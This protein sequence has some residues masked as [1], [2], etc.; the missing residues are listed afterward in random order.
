MFKNDDDVNKD[1]KTLTLHPQKD[2]MPLLEKGMHPV[3][4]AARGLDAHIEKVCNAMR[5]LADYIG[6][7]SLQHQIWWSEADDFM[8]SIA[9]VQLEKASLNHMAFILE[10][11][12]QG[13]NYEAVCQYSK[14]YG[15]VYRGIPANDVLYGSGMRMASSA[16]TPFAR[17]M[18]PMAHCCLLHYVRRR[19]DFIAA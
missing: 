6:V 12:A 19:P 13:F 10:L 4:A 11:D 7:C 5:V 17:P 3:I 1:Q 8:L 9:T 16:P 2:K 14:T 15:A 18:R